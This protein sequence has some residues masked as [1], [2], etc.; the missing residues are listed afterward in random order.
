MFG[1]HIG[2]QLFRR[3]AFFFRPQHD[4]RAM[5]IVGTDVDTLVAA[6]FL[7]TNPDVGL[8]VFQHMA[9]VNRT[10][11]IGQGAGNQN[12]TGVCSRHSLSALAG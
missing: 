4:G 2:N 1:V 3:D 9:K 12:L 10:V 7:E 5:G 8:N 11:G 6:Q